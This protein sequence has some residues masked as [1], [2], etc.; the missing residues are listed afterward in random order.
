MHLS[1]RLKTIVDMIPWGSHV[2]DVGCDHGLLSIYLALYNGASCI[3]T[4]INENALRNAKCN[5]RKYK[6]PN[7][8]IVLTDGLENICFNDNDYIV[9]AGMGTKT[10]THILAHKKLSCN[11]IISSNNQLYELR[12]F[13]T[14]LGYMIID[15]KFVVEHQ[16]KYVII[17]FRK[18]KVRY[19]KR[20]LEY[21]PIVSRDKEYLRYELSK[22]IEIKNNLMHANIKLRLKNYLKILTIKKILKKAR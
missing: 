2:I 1:R 6:A 4:D 17:K 11:L 12:R 16:K 18:G 22:L 14:K 3:A 13:V 10:I 15:E 5:I 20:Q 19:N 21:G 8:S 9:I 7:I